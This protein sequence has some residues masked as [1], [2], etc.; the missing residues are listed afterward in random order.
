MEGLIP[1]EFG[2]DAVEIPGSRAL[3]DKL[4]AAGA[5]WMIVTSGTKPL[6]NGWLD[7]MKLVHPQQLVSAEDVQDGK[8]DPSCY[9]LGRSKLGLPNTAD[10]IVLED[11]PAGVRAGKKAG[12]RVVA[13]ATTHKIEQLQREG[14]DWIVEDMRSVKLKSW[15]GNSGIVDIEIVNALRAA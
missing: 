1:K 11:S 7:V 6:V 15:D 13:L 9:L 5:P 12:F 14:A 10:C 8:P 3:L 2:Q 4:S